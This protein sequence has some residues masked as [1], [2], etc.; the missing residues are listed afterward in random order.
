MNNPSDM[1]FHCDTIPIMEQIFPMN[2]MMGRCVSLGIKN[3]I[4]SIIA[5]FP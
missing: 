5:L 2:P 4:L 3:L 1:I